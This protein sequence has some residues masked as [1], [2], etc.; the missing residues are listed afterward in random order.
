MEH[1]KSLSLRKIEDLA[2][3]LDLELA[4]RKIL[5]AALASKNQRWQELVTNRTRQPK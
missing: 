4:P 2:K 5:I 1:Q 3:A